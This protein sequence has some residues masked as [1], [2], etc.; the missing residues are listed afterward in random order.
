M[1]Y[2]G[3]VVFC[4][5]WPQLGLSKREPEDD[6]DD[7]DDDDFLSSFKLTSFSSFPHGPRAPGPVVEQEP[8]S[9]SPPL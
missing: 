2:P 4:P 5:G 7:D 3:S 1:F 6:D 8:E 9:P